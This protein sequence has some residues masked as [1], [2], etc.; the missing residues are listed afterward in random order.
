[1]TDCE[2]MMMTCEMRVSLAELTNDTEYIE[3][4]E[5]CLLNIEMNRLMLE[6]QAEALKEIPEEYAQQRFGITRDE[7]DYTHFEMMCEEKSKYCFPAYVI[8]QTIE[9]FGILESEPNYGSPCETPL[10]VNE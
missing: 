4:C 7:M 1:M 10:E 2:H 8:L 9:V 3:P 5:P 6:T